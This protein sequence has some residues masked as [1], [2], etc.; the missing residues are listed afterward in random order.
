MLKTNKDKKIR[1]A[2]NRWKGSTIFDYEINKDCL[3]FYFA[4]YDFFVKSWF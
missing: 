2:S 1:F 3:N 4:T